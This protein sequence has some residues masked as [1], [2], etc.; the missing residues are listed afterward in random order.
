MAVYLIACAYDDVDHAVDLEVYFEGP[1]DLEPGEVDAIFR[2]MLSTGEI[3][4]GWDFEAA[5]WDHGT[6]SGDWSDV[7]HFRE[8]FRAV[9]LDIV[10][11][12]T[13]GEVDDDADVDE[14]DD[15]DEGEG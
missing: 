6:G 2:E 10:D 11:L 13:R 3:P 9:D 12:E 7:E 1:D 4:E 14:G 15:D 8:L 5:L